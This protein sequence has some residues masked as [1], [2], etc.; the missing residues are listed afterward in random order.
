MGERDELGRRGVE[1]LLE[2]A[3]RLY[4][5]ARYVEALRAAERAVEGARGLGDLGLE[6]KAI[7][8]EARP[9]NMLGDSGATLARLS[10]ILGI[11][12][13][14]AR[15]AEVEQAGVEWEIAGAYGM[16]VDAALFVTEV[17]TQRLFA[18]LDAGEAYVR[19]IGR[20]GW[21]AGLVFYRARILDQL[22]RTE[23]A[24]GAAEEG[25]SLQLRDGSGP[26][27]T[28]ATHRLMLGNLL[29]MAERYDNAGAQYQAAI[30]DPQTSTFGRMGGLE[31]LSRCMLATGD[32]S[33][34]RLHASRAVRLAE[35]MGDEALATPLEVL[36][37]A[38]R[39][40]GDLPAAREASERKLQGARRLGS[41]VRLYFALRR[42]GDV[43]LDEKDAA[44]ARA[45]IDEAEPHAEAL[46]RQRGRT[47]FT[48]E[49]QRYRARLAELGPAGGAA[50]PGSNTPAGQ[51]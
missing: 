28:L 42:A 17:P 9:L 18:V 10:W 26:G 44:R 51:G 15:R 16:W 31:G 19:S 7:R 47:M 21:R 29:R 46:D 41:V 48:D 6:I 34:A 3:S 33:A 35:G 1:L 43:A 20:P 32:I 13:D 8:E 4:H 25:L 2:E 45:L 14:P 11:V 39:A 40:S 24:I 38:C 23:E 12:G 30:D 22:G 5:E 49:I 50:E 27:P 36:I 37:E